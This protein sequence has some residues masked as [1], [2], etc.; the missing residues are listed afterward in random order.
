MRKINVDI[1]SSI[2]SDSSTTRTAH[3]IKHSKTIRI[4]FSKLLKWHFDANGNLVHESGKF[5]TVQGLSYGQTSG[6]GRRE[7]LILN[8]PETGILGILG[9]K[10]NGILHFLMQFKFE[11]GNIGEVQLS[12]TVQ[13]T[14]SNYTAVHKGKPVPYLDYF[15][16]DKNTL[17]DLPLSEQAS[18][19]FKKENRNSIRIYDESEHIE[20]LPGFQWMT[21]SQILRF[22]KEDNVVN[23]NARSI[24]SGILLGEEEEKY[25]LKDAGLL[26]DSFRKNTP[27]PH[28]KDLFISSLNLDGTYTDAAG[29]KSWIDEMKTHSEIKA[30]LKSIK[31]MAHINRTDMEFSCGPDPDFKIIALSIMA[32][33][34]VGSWTQPV[35]CDSHIRIHGMLAKKINDILH[36]LVRGKEEPGSINGA[37]IGPT[38]QGIPLSYLASS[39]ELFAKYF[40]APEKKN[41]IISSMQSDEGGRFYRV[42]NLHMVVLTTDDIPL[43]PGFMWATLRQIKQLV[44]QPGYVN[45]EARSLISCISYH[46]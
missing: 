24:I 25:T 31:N 23:M 6:P 46:E 20:L 18:R 11:P 30:K 5:F 19:F 22:I 3:E 21:L 43:Q 45:I 2:F 12:P 15:L 27:S 28:G 8:Q 39:P 33:R 32:E 29:F 36:F 13:A 14:K 16:S 34:E 17:F 4:P 41:I 9:K 26:Y 37:E 35:I 7:Q 1:L 40:I 10:V 44:M 42:Q 38:I